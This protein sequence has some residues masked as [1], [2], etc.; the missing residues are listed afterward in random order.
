MKRRR[1]REVESILRHVF[2]WIGNVEK[3]GLQEVI[4]EKMVVVKFLALNV[5]RGCVNVFFLIA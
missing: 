1:G 2:G 4:A 5:G 3:R